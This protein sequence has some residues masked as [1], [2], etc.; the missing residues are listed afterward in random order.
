MLQEIAWLQNPCCNAAIQATL[1][2]GFGAGVVPGTCGKIICSPQFPE[3]G[4]G[5][6]HCN[7]PQWRTWCVGSFWL[8]EHLVC[9]LV[10]WRS[11]S[12]SGT[13]SWLW[14]ISYIRAGLAAS[15]LTAWLRPLSIRS[16]PKLNYG[17]GRDLGVG[18]E[19]GAMWKQRIIPGNARARS[20]A[21]EEDWVTWLNLRPG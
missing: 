12:S 16:R 13:L 4:Q 19:F 5:A 2:P 18:P 9:R 6:D 11:G 17:A 3:Y 8:W 21:G 10:G 15:L 20:C 14:M 7:Q 1:H